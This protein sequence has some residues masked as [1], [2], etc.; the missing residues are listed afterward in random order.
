MWQ[1][2]SWI[3]KGERISISSATFSYSYAW[4]EK[5]TLLRF[6]LWGSKFRNFF[7]LLFPS[8]RAVNSQNNIRKGKFHFVSAEPI[9]KSV[10]YLVLHGVKKPSVVDLWTY[11]PWNSNFYNTFHKVTSNERGKTKPIIQHVS[12]RTA[13]GRVLIFQKLPK[14]TATLSPFQSQN[15]NQS[16]AFGI[17]CKTETKKTGIIRW[18]KSLSKP[19]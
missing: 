16:S 3:K 9:Q 2:V 18:L 8:L 1:V 10:Y 19:K 13:N 5:K 4:C 17:S 11:S 7:P 12:Q 14:S 15:S 6:F